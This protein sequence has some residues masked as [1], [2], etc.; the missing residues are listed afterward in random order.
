MQSNSIIE[1]QGVQAVAHAG[2]GLAC[3]VVWGPG[4]QSPRLPLSISIYEPA[5]V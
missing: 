4:G 5:V 3:P 1:L 2:R